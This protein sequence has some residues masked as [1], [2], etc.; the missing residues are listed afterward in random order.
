MAVGELK[1]YDQR[2]GR[3]IYNAVSLTLRN[4][5]VVDDLAVLIAGEP[6]WGSDAPTKFPSLNEMATRRIVDG[7]FVLVNPGKPEQYFLD[8]VY[9]PIPGLIW[10][11]QADNQGLV[12]LKMLG[13][14]AMLDASRPYTEDMRVF[15]AANTGWKS[16]SCKG[17][18]L[19]LLSQRE[20]RQLVADQ[21][22]LAKRLS[23]KPDEAATT[24]A[25]EGEV[26]AFAGGFGLLYWAQHLYNR[27]EEI[28]HEMRE[29]ASK[30][31]R[32][33]VISGET[34]SREEAA[35]AIA[36]AVH[37]IIFPGP[38][39]IERMVSEAVL[40]QLA[41]EAD[42]RLG[43]YFDAM[44]SL[45]KESANRPVARDREMRSQVMST[46]I[47][48]E[49]AALSRIYA[50]WGIGLSFRRVIITTA[51]ER[52]QEKDLLDNSARELGSDEHDKRVRALFGL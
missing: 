13:S 5:S 14:G 20:L 46:Y 43:D 8:H 27:Y 28:S 30:V 11:F 19:A 47:D 51:A 42:L 44:N 24:A 6:I 1:F 25:N 32:L 45:D 23:L 48:N 26:Y 37:A 40:R 18:D 2:L 12:T 52:Q 41:G 22:S 7:S 16:Y 17:K 9:V 35:A 21:D 15:V 36:T 4:R 10:E 3:D 50:D 34:G 39:V 38:V 29:S 33:P 31:N 49:H